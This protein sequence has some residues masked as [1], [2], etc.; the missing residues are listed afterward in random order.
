MIIQA[1]TLLALCN[2]YSAL[3]VTQYHH[4]DP[5]QTLFLLSHCFFDPGL[6]QNP[7][8]NHDDINATAVRHQLPMRH[9]CMAGLRP[10][11]ERQRQAPPKPPLHSTTLH[12]STKLNYTLWIHYTPLQSTTLEHSTTV[13]STKTLHS[14]RRRTISATTKIQLNGNS[15]VQNYGTE[16]LIDNRIICGKCLKFLQPKVLHCW[17]FLKFCWC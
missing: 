4:R 1:V 12:G 15:S 5:F 7:Q 14:R 3:C 9:P 6:K 8:T 17:S 10:L 11:L 16:R 13:A 2:R